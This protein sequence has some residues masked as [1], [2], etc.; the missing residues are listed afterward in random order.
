VLCS[1]LWQRYP[2]DFPC[3]ILELN[4]ILFA[5]VGEEQKME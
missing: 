3:S 1:G 4:D 2:L 5:S